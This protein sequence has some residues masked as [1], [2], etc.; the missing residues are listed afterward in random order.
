MFVYG[1]LLLYINRKALPAPLKVRGY[2]VAALV[3]VVVLFGVL[4]VLTV[5]QQIMDVF[6]G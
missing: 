5:R 1:G 2:R 6:G 3:W 4:S